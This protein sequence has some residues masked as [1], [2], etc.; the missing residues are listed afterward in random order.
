MM[1]S[2]EVELWICR[3]LF[4]ENEYERVIEVIKKGLVKNPGNQVLVFNLAL[5]MQ[6]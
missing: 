2:E 6:A 1:N 3:A 5:T 4:N